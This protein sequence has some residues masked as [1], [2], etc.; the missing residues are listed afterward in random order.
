LYGLV[1]YNCRIAPEYFLYSMTIAEA[2]L[3]LEQYNK[4]YRD[5]WDRTRY[6]CYVTACSMGAK[7]K[8]PQ[9]LM[10]FPWE[11]KEKV[12][13]P[14]PSQSEIEKLRKE[15]QASY[16]NFIKGKGEVWKPDLSLMD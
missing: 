9:D 15:S 6:I 10:L 8:K 4:E 12:I 16:D 1:V 14:K 11:V 3:V 2:E 13:A 5:G 7:L